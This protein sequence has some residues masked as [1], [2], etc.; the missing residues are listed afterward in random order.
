[1]DKIIIIFGVFSILTLVLCVCWIFYNIIQF[2]L[3]LFRFALLE[4]FL[5]VVIKLF[6]WL[7]IKKH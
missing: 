2:D 1:M 3:N 4:L 6:H 5:Y 7:F